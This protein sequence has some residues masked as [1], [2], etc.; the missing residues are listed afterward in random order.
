V[1]VLLG[2]AV[3]AILWPRSDWRYTARPRRIIETYVDCPDPLSLPEM[4][5]ELA[6]YLDTN[7]LKNRGQLSV[8]TK[9]FRAASVLLTVEVLAWA[10]D[11]VWQA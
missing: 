8:L 3:L 6:L 5:R 1:F 4:H 7:Y 10:V 9:L 2:A 11:L